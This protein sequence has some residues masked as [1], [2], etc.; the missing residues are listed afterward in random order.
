MGAG[1]KFPKKLVADRGK[2]AHNYGF[3]NLVRCFER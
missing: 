1:E 2:N 3:E